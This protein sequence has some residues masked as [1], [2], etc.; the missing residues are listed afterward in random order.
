M[1]QAFC[2]EINP[3]KINQRI[4][5]DLKNI[6]E[7]LRANRIALNTNKTKIV[8]FRSPRKIVTQKMNFRISGQK[9]KIKHSANI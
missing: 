1:T 7:W 8:L 4:N 6:V 2:I 3:L 9:I 5:H